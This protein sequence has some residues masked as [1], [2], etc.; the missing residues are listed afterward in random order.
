M[1]EVKTP[2]SLNEHQPKYNEGAWTEYTLQELG[3]WVHLFTKRSYHR[4][5]H[6]KRAKDLL[7]AQNYL[8]MMQAQL[9]AAKNDAEAAKQ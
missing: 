1:A 7:D 6:D 9:D 3:N 5:D 2:E 8:N 4:K